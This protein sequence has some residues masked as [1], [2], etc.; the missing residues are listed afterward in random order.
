MSDNGLNVF[1]IF[2]FDSNI[3]H[4]GLGHRELWIINLK[5]ICALFCQEVH[6]VEIQYCCLYESCLQ[7]SHESNLCYGRLN[8]HI[9]A[10]C[11]SY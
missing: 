9:E 5:S 6:Q 2:C 8:D 10:Y 3:H 7:Y 4:L 11:P 1:Y